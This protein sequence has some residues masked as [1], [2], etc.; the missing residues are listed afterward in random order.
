[1]SVPSFGSVAAAARRRNLWFFRE[2]KKRFVIRHT[3]DGIP[4]RFDGLAQAERYIFSF[5]K[6]SIY[7]PY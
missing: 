7:R 4:M 2:G 3:R 5:E 6:K 1:M